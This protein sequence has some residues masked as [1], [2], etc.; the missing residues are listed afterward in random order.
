MCTVFCSLYFAIF[1]LCLGTFC[2]V[3]CTVGE[4]LWRLGQGERWSNRRCREHR[5]GDL[6]AAYSARVSDRE[7]FVRVRDRVRDP[8]RGGLDGMSGVAGMSE[9][10]GL[11]QRWDGIGETGD[12]VSHAS[13]CG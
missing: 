11:K 9:P 12:G 13:F 4:I 5:S 3:D 8:S 2:L 1:S 7:Q 10:E 6:R